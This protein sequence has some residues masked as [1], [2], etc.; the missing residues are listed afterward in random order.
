MEIKELLSLALDNK[1]SDLH[2][3]S[4]LQPFI[5]VDGQLQKLSLSALEDKELTRLLMGI[6]NEE[7]HR[8]YKEQLDIDFAYEPLVGLRLRVNVFRQ[9]RG[10]S[11]AFR[12]IPAEIKSLHELE[13]PLIFQ[14][15][16]VFPSS[17]WL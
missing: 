4:G 2:L 14:D 7:Q 11:A 5:R 1:A 16:T 12:L 6:M 10:I 17:N 8:L 15:V 13:F 9:A 3:S